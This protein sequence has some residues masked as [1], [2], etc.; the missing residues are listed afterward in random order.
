MQDI[1]RSPPWHSVRRRPQAWGSAITYAKRYAIGALLNL[2]IDE[3][4]DGN[5][6][7]LY[8]GFYNVNIK[9]YQDYESPQVIVTTDRFGYQESFEGRYNATDSQEIYTLGNNWLIAN[10][11]ITN[12]GYYNT[13][14][15]INSDTSL[16]NLRVI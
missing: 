2:C 8:N 4:D 13:K 16:N 6:I 12:V 7:D 15:S 11:T 14:L 5:Y 3:D 1:Q 10:Y 9:P